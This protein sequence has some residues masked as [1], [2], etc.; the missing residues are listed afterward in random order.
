MKKKIL[1][2]LSIL[3]IAA[4]AITGTV[5]YLTDEAS[6]INVMTVGNVKIQQLEYER[7]ANGDLQKFTQDKPI[8]PAVY[9]GTSL[10]WADGLYTWDSIDG[11]PAGAGNQLFK[12]GANAVDKFVFVKNTGKTDAYYRTIIAIECPE[13]LDP[14][15]I[16]IN[17]NGNARFTWSDIGFTTLNGVK[18]Y[19]KEAL[20]NEILVPGE[21]SRPSLLQVYLDKA[22][23]NEDLALFGEVMEILVVSQAVQADGWSDANTALDTAFYD[24][25]TDAHP[26][27]N[28]VVVPDFVASAEEFAEALANAKAGDTVKLVAGDYGDLSISGEV[29]GVTITAEEGVNARFNILSSAVLTDVTFDSMNLTYTA[30]SGAYVDGGAINI[31]AGASVKNL[32][33]ENSVFNGTGGRSSVVGVSEPTAEVT[34]RNCEVNGPKYLVYGSAPIAVLN[35]E[36]CKLNNISSWLVMMNAADAV[37]AKL[38]ITGNTMNNCDGGI[39]KYLGG[40]QPDGAATVFADND[41]T[42]CEGHDGSD[43]KWFTIPGAAA[44]VSVSGNTLEGLTWEPG[45]AQ[46]LGK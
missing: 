17:A 30:N 43:A 33:I 15:L 44:T 37:G 20:Y 31:D 41:L 1:V 22:A 3:L 25:T 12:D 13:G 8:V 36:D 35:V 27:V 16:H 34:I 14:S 9:D 39:A 18:Y 38:S 40:S 29:N 6:D 23:T 24:V 4:M 42:D 28:G 45:T 21:T 26:W 11:V 46:G 32:V 5:A 7:D 10:P 19:L 2:V